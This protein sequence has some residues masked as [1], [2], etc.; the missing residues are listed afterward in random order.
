MPHSSTSSYTK[1]VP[2][3][4]LLGLGACAPV[5]PGLEMPLD[6]LIEDGEIVGEGKEDDFLSMS[7][8]EFV[9]A[10]T[11]TVVLE[12]E[13]ADRSD[14]DRLARAHELIALRQIALA[15]FLNQYLVDKSDDDANAQFGGF[16]AMSKAGDY[17]ALNVRETAPLTYAFDFEQLVAGRV[18]LM[19]RLPTRPGPSATARLFTL[20]VGRPTNAEMARLETNAEWYRSAPWS[21][22]NPSTTDASRR[23]DLEVTIRREVESQDAWFDYVR[24]FEDGVLDIDVHFGWDYHDAYHV[25]HASALHSWLR[26]QGFRAPV[27]SFEELRRD[28]GPYTRTLRANGRTIQLEVRI[29]YGRDDSDVDP[30][31][32]A[33]GRQLEDDM[34][35]SLATRDVIV[36]SGHS[37]PFYGFALANWR[38]TSEG[39]L[40]DSELETAEMP[41]DRYQIVLA[42][43]CDTYQIG[44][45]FRRNPN[46]P[47]LRNLDVITTTSFSNAS[48][49]AAVQDFLSRLIERDSR[50]RHRPRTVRSLLTDLDDNSGWGFHTMY[51]MHGIDDAPQLHPYA[52]AEMIG[53]L[54]SVNADCGDIGNMCVRMPD[55]TRRCTAVCTSDDAC[56]EGWS[57]RPLA[58]SVQRA[59][60]G[61]ACAPLP[62][63]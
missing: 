28:S 13:Y 48:T 17:A 10:G 16:G 7:A 32:D 8:R 22:W 42:E 59:I 26:A 51:G 60:Y 41:A 55:R 45:A 20:T 61:S 4:G 36:Y 5:E 47:D 52:D 49:P 21:A 23:L 58:S 31:T 40:D 35:G 24:L 2:L 57:C 15:W 56:G 18:D 6:E 14:E 33:G 11:D 12:D 29:F 62:T 1:L 37:G 9:I 63:R 46:K 25:Q 27:A 53:E 19:T 44:A 39:D 38:T 43:G 34:R 3:L 50:G 30:D 54:C